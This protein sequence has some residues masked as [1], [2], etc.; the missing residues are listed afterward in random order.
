MKKI[1][2]L[3]EYTVYDNKGGLL[4]NG[5]FKVKNKSSSIEAQIDFEAFLKKKYNNFGKL[6]VHKCEEE[7]DF[8]SMFGDIFK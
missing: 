1:I 6:I 3:I 4:K 5:K 8:L 2:Y 7:S